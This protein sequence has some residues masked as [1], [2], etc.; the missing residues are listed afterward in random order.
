MK[1]KQTKIENYHE[2]WDSAFAA[3]RQFVPQAVRTGK[4]E[5]PLP[6]FVREFIQNAFHSDRCS[7]EQIGSWAKVAVFEWSDAELRYNKN[8]TTFEEIVKAI[9]FWLD[10]QTAI[11][12]KLSTVADAAE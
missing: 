3:L 2:N 11:L 9:V 1:N 7:R 8:E 6:H 10:Q 5:P 12:E 4:L